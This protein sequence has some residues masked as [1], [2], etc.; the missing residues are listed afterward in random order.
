MEAQEEILPQNSE[1]GGAPA[2]SRDHDCIIEP[3]RWQAP[4]TGETQGRETLKSHI[5]PF[6]ILLGGQKCKLLYAMISSQLAHTLP[7]QSL[8]LKSDYS[9]ALSLHLST[10]NILRP[11]LFVMVELSVLCIV[12]C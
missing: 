9:R 7:W 12:R 2:I 3:P 5:I 8:Y 1:Q 11:Q 6:L 10:T 4:G